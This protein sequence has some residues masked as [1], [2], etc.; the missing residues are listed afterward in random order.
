YWKAQLGDDHPVLQ[1]PADHPRKADGVYSAA[2]H[3]LEL[4]SELVQGLHQRERAEGATLFMVLLAG[5]QAL[6]HRY[7]GQQ[8]IRVGVPIANR[9]R[10]ETEGVVGFFVNTQ[11]LRNVIGGRLSLAQVLKQAK[12]AALG[13]QT[14]QDLPFEQLVEALQPERNLGTNPLFQV[15]FNHQRQDHRALQQL[16][17]LTLEDYAL[18][19]QHAQFELTVDTVEDADGQ[20]RVSFTYA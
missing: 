20:V 18:G 8:D 2:R 19:E 14:H 13:A 17:G 16:P 12:E 15:M 4:P 9:H 11:V 6:L 3:G 10:V 1:L 7:S 5:V